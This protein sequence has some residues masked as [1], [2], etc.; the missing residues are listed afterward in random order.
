M[1]FTDLNSFLTWVNTQGLYQQF[2]A[3]SYTQAISPGDWFRND[4]Q[5]AIGIWNGFQGGSS[6]P[7]ND[8]REP[9]GSAYTAPVTPPAGTTFA[10]LAEKSTAAL[11]VAGLI[12]STPAPAFALTIPS[13]PSSP[14]H[15]GGEGL[16]VALLTGALVFAHS[17]AVRRLKPRSKRSK[18]A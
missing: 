13:A 10:E 18:R 12:K 4:Y 2:Q 15:A 6:S 14:V 17:R 3:F 1:R 9:A 16:F 11:P 5:F 7:T 8:A